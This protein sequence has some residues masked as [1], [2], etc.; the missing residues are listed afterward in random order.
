MSDI[1]KA[2]DVRGIYP[3]EINAGT[4]KQIGNA[5]VSF[6]KAKTMVVGEDARLSSPELGQAAISGITSAGCDVYDIGQCTTPLFYFS[7]NKL[8]A[9][10][11]IMVTASHNPPE[12]NG[13]KIVGE[14][15]RPI[16]M[17]TGLLEIKKL[18]SLEIYGNKNGGVK[19]TSLKEEYVDFLLNESKNIS[20]KA[21][22]LKIVIDASN[23]MT[24]IVLNDFLPKTKLNILPL[25]FDIDGTFPNHLSDTSREENLK[26]LKNK[27]IS[28]KADIGIAFDSDGDRMAVIDERGSM[29][30]ADMVT[31]LLFRRF[32]KDSRVAYDS[33]FS[34]S[35]K[36]IFGENGVAS[37]TGHSFVKTTMRQNDCS[38]GGELSGHFFFKEMNYADSA[39][40]A[41]LRFVE[42]L[43]KEDEPLSQLVAPLIIYANSGE[44]N[45]EF[46]GDRKKLLDVLKEKYSDGKRSFLDGITVDM[47]N[48]PPPAGGWWFNARFSNT[49][50]LVRIVVEAETK[51]LMQEKV[52]ELKSVVL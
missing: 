15:S 32:Y 41:M 16:S 45:I 49:E 30:R 44:I 8:G 28:E 2:Y 9:D 33:R 25:Y 20:D 50:P 39:I 7:V 37:K 36:E 13:L 51:K 38:F 46:R 19:E 48:I 3:E 29:V 22:E 6:L 1:F 5:T 35:V 21:K 31:A 34:R 42:L 27:V 4:V 11:G 12:Y 43:A 17:D 52:D 23:G 47:W 10:G 26:D 40:L 24:P 14:K 18:S